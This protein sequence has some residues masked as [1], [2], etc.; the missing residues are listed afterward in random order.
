[1]GKRDIKY[2]NEHYKYLT[3]EQ[4]LFLKYLVEHKG[5]YFNLS[6]PTNLRNVPVIQMENK[7]IPLPYLKEFCHRLGLNIEQLKRI[8]L[9]DECP[10][11][12]V[13]VIGGIDIKDAEQILKE[14]KEYVSKQIKKFLK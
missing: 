5:D 2:I 14:L 9:M 1:M 10:I 12:M 7:M 3:E 4:R 11:E 6:I 13:A 8:A